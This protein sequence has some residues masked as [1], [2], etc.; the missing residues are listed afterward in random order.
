MWR[1]HR[2]IHLLT[3]AWKGA[4]N[5]ERPPRDTLTDC[6][7]EGSMECGETTERYTY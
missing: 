7:M 4:W 3:V 2:E 6:G 1:D 5:V